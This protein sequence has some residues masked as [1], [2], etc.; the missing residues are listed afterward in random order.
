MPKQQEQQPT[1]EQQEPT[2]EQEAVMMLKCE[3]EQAKWATLEALRFTAPT[4]AEIRK[5][6][7]SGLAMLRSSCQYLETVAEMYRRKWQNA[8]LLLKSEAMVLPPPRARS[9]SAD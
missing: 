7:D 6:D 8:C 5:N 2:K 4:L 9:P 1:E 3:L